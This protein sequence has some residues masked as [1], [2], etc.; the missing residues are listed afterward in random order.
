MRGNF[1]YTSNKTVMDVIQQA[2]RK[3]SRK[4][5]G[6]YMDVE[7][8]VQEAH[9][10]VSI[11]TNLQSAI[12][13][14]EY[15]LLQFRLEQDLTDRLDKE[16]RRHSKNVSY[17]AREEALGEATAV[18]GRLFSDLSTSGFRTGEAAA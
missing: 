15:G 9:V 17:E 6:R 3:T 12:I 8:L 13:A 1:D 4:F 10:M 2:A 18:S 5:G 16:V 11:T 7:D 14:E